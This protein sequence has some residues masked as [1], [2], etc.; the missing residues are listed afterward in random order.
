MRIFLIIIAIIIAILGLTFALL[1]A[2][3][4]MLNYYIGTLTISLSLLLV[5]TVGIGILI[6]F[7][8]TLSS[9]LKL[10]RKNYQLK[11]RIKQLEHEVLA[12]KVPDTKGLQ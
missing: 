10:K 6:G 4:V 7:L 1:N 12:S 11:S 9:I 8:A 2:A 3:P 5:L